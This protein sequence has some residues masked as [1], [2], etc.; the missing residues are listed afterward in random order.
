[1]IEKLNAKGT[2]FRLLNSAAYSP[3]FSKRF[4]EELF[5]EC[6]FADPLIY[7]RQNELVSGIL[8]HENDRDVQSEFLHDK[9]KNL[10]SILNDSSIR[11]SLRYKDAVIALPGDTAASSWLRNSP[12][13]CTVLKVPHHGHRDGISEELV[14]VLKPE[15][16][17]LSVSN[18]RKDLCPHPDSVGIIKKN[19]KK[20]F[21]TDALSIPGLTEGIFHSS[22]RFE[23]DEGL[24]FAGSHMCPV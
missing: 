21:V 4:G 20:C 13:K 5:V 3:S 24:I 10:N 8:S 16:S 12:S 6:T 9:I 17:V 2:A 18:D 22:V 15:Y 23:F 11:V 14:S 1:M 19:V 7:R